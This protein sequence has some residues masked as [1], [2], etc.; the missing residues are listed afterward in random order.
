MT[1]EA[2]SV[3]AQ[4]ALHGKVLDDEGYQVVACSN[5]DLSRANF[6]DALGRFTPGQLASLPHLSKD[7]LCATWKRVFQFSPPR[8]LRSGC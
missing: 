1:V 4:W 5:G 2:I 3:R 6:A 8:Q 7:E